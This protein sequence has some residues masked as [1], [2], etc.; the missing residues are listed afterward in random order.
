MVAKSSFL[1]SPLPGG[2]EGQGEG[3]ENLLASGI[4]PARKGKMTDKGFQPLMEQ[5]R[6]AG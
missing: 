2:S 6:A 4:M 5:V 3:E 1:L